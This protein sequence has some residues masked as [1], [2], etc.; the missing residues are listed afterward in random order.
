MWALPVHKLQKP[1]PLY[2]SLSY[3]AVHIT[4]KKK[5]EFEEYGMRMRRSLNVG[6]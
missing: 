3:H 6:I 4:S 2:T 1:F 5:K